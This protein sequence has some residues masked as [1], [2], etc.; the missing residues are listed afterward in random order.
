[1]EKGAIP[2]T[3]AL[4]VSCLQPGFEALRGHFKLCQS[5]ASGIF[6]VAS[7]NYLEMRQ[8]SFALDGRYI[9]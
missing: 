2:G 5:Y 6:C 9:Y 7:T 4:L 1:M 8:A 3:A